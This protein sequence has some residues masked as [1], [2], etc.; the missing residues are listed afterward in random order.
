M[1]RNRGFK[2]DRQRR[3]FFA[4]MNFKR[5]PRNIV[6]TSRPKLPLAQREF[7]ATEIRRGVKEGRPQDQSIAIAF[8]KARKR[9]GNG[10][11]LP[12]V[13]SGKIQKMNFSNPKNKNFSSNPN[14]TTK[15]RTRN[16]LVLILGTA[17]ALRL[18]RDISKRR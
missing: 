7:I 10:A 5:Q 13:G 1:V 12:K 18:L 9:F 11:L 15:K 3:G 2:T 6:M 14:G 4:T 17:I 16:L 8:S